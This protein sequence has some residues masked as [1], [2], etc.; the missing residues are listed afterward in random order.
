M[1]KGTAIAPAMELYR[2]AREN[3]VAV[4]FITGRP[5]RT[6]EATEKNLREVGYDVWEKAVL[7]PNDMKVPSAADYKGPVRCELVA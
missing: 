5:E 3:N 7:K 2:F 4:F 1:A 6:R